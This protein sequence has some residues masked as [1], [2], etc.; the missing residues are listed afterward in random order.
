MINEATF[1][2]PRVYLEYPPK[3]TFGGLK[4]GTVCMTEFRPQVEYII[5]QALTSNR[6]E[7]ASETQQM[8][9]YQ[10]RGGYYSKRQKFQ[11][12]QFSRI[13]HVTKHQLL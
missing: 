7:R 2:H 8:A 9:S 1:G 3:H 4:V 11:S 13:N 6:V 10:S 5:S 12:L